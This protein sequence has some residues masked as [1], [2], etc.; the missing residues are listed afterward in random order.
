MLSSK[1]GTKEHFCHQIEG[2]LLAKK[3]RQG[4]SEKNIFKDF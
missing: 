2:I 1:G 4:D 3:F